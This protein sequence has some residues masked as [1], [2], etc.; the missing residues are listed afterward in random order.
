[1][2]EGSFAIHTLCERAGFARVG[3]HEFTMGRCVQVDW[4][5]L[6]RL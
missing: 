2:R 5:M 4:I 3:E 1:V 6:K